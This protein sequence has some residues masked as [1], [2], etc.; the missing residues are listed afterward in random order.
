M[1]EPLVIQ[2]L[3][4]YP[5][6]SLAG[7]RLMVAKVEEKGFELDRRWML[8]DETGQFLSQRS[9]PLMAMLHVEIGVDSLRVYHISNPSDFIHI[10]IAEEGDAISSVTVWDDE[11]PARLVNPKIDHWFSK[12]LGRNV[13]LV[14]MPDTTERKVDP[15]YAVNGESVSFADGMPYLLIGQESLEDLNSRLE[16]PVPMNRFRPNIVFSGG[17][18]FAEDSWKKMQIGDLYFQVIKPCARCIMTTVDQETGI[19]A[20]EP[21]KTLATYRKVGN[22]ILFGQNMVALS[23]GIIKVGDKIKSI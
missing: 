2:D 7:V 19:K 21:L 10:P 16:T 6:K 14:K 5:I 22:K 20:A 18:S 11:M 1:P 17:E 12:T 3:Y 13:R 15:R 23:S 9:F 8:I 4:I